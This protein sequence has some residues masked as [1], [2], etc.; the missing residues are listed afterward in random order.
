M[1]TPE[2]AMAL[3]TFS[4]QLQRA[5]ELAVE[6]HRLL[7]RARRDLKTGSV[8]IRQSH[9]DIVDTESILRRNKPPQP[10][11]NQAS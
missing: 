10:P 2:A 3:V 1:T 7:H 4:K 8:L 6:G 9:R 11:A 5:R